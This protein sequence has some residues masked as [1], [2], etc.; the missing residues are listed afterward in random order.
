M[1]VK[2]Y[3]TAAVLTFVAVVA[4]SLPAHANTDIVKAYKAAFEGSKPKCS[5]CHVLALP[6]KDEGQHDLNEYGQKVKDAG[7]EEITSEVL[8]S[9]GTREDFDTASAQ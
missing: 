1:D 2:Q 4:V 7:G 9:V 8:K 6:K 3:R 5:F